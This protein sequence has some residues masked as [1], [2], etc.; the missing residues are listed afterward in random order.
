MSGSDL[1][2]KLG[3]L[4]AVNVPKVTFRVCFGKFHRRRIWRWCSKVRIVGLDR[5]RRC[6]KVEENVKKVR[7]NLEVR[8][9]LRNFA[10][11]DEGMRRLTEAVWNT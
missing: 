9:C 3:R 10:C 4:G 8:K 11:G 7:K 2:A 6:K 1:R 5:R